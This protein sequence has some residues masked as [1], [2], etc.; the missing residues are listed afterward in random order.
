M[1]SVRSWINAGNEARFNSLA[2]KASGP[3]AELLPDLV[4]DLPVEHREPVPATSENACRPEYRDVGG[5]R[6]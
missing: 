4:S 6:H 5:H 2:A 1:L 3:F